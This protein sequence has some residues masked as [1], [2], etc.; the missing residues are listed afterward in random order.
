MVFLCVSQQGEFK[1]TTKKL[2]WGS[3]IFSI[4]L[5]FNAFLAVSLH[6]EPKNNIKI[7]NPPPPPQKISKNLKKRQEGGTAF[8]FFS[9]APLVLVC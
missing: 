3:L 6:K 8:V 7:I 2:V 4:D 1:N 5:F 9:S